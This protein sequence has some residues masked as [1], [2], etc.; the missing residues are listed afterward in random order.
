MPE[1][2][3]IAKNQSVYTD[4]SGIISLL[5]YYNYAKKL[6]NC[7]VTLNFDGINFIDANLCAFLYGIIFDLR[8][9]YGVKTFIEFKTIGRDLNVLMRNGFTNFV[10]GK[11]FQFIPYD[12]RDTT[13]PLKHCRY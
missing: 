4:F 13:I 11:E 1:Y 3:L 9:N 6:R 12:S 10:A 5:N 2:S 8:K 7:W